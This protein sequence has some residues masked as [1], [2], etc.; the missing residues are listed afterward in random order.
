MSDLD[1]YQSDSAL[2]GGQVEDVQRYRSTQALRAR[3]GCGCWASG[4][5]GAGV[6]PA[7]TWC[8]VVAAWLSA[9]LPLPVAPIAGTAAQ[10]GL[11]DSSNDVQTTSSRTASGQCD[12]A[13][14]TRDELSTLRQCLRSAVLLWRRVLLL[15][16]VNRV[17]CLRLFAF[18]LVC[19]CAPLR[20]ISAMFNIVTD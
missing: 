8:A 11:P 1:R 13:R 15:L 17:A 20:L 7:V 14:P 19:V 3:A 10:T 16:P 9:L 4:R 5:A 18:L 2:Y 6:A 12:T